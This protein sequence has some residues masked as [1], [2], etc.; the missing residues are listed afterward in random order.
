MIAL[1]RNSIDSSEDRDQRQ[2]VSKLD[3]TSSLPAVR[4]RPANAKTVALIEMLIPTNTAP[5]AKARERS[6][7][8]VCS[9]MVVVIVLV[10]PRML[11]PTRIS[12][13]PPKRCDQS[14]PGRLSKV[15]A[16]DHQNLWKG[17]Q[18]RCA[19]ASQF[20]A[21]ARP[22][23]FAGAMHECRNDRVA[24]MVCAITMAVGVKS[25]AREPK[26]PER[27][28]A[29][30]STRP[31][32][33]GGKPKNALINT[34]ISRRP[35]KRKIAST[36]PIGRLTPAAMAV[37]ARLTLIESPTISRKSPKR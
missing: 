17:L 10:K 32:T 18:S 3:H 19:I 36:A 14:P 12:H 7:W 21:I 5:R 6:P 31:T 20:V 29:R 23:S 25:S 26:G 22:S 27:E 4:A 11:P 34:T 8:L 9:A 13:R 35:R 28:R 30:Y 15:G 37:A 16:N 1:R 33:T 24:S 2:H